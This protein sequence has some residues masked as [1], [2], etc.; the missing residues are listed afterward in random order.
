MSVAAPEF[1]P[2][3]IDVDGTKIAVRYRAGDKLPGVVWARRLSLRT[4]SAPRRSFST[5]GPG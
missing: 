1:T 5:N 4:C 3:F 2:E